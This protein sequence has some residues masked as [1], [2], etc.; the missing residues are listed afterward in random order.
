[1]KKMYIPSPS[2]S[3]FYR[4]N[5]QTNYLIM[6][7]W[8]QRRRRHKIIKRSFVERKNWIIWRWKSYF[9]R[10]TMNHLKPVECDSMKVSKL[11][12]SNI[13]LKMSLLSLEKCHRKTSLSLYHHF[14]KSK[15]WPFSTLFTALIINSLIHRKSLL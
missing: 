11:I 9:S 13:R 4:R 15:N 8:W 1:M 12:M 5:K 14:Q 2:T 10:A 7:A 3:H 6:F